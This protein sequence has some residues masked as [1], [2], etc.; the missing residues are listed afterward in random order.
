[1]ATAADHSSRRIR[2]GATTGVGMIT[3]AVEAEAGAEAGVNMVVPIFD[4][5]HNVFVA[6][7]IWLYGF[8]SP[9]RIHSFIRIKHLANVYMLEHPFIHRQSFPAGF[10]LLAGAIHLMDSSPFL[11]WVRLLIFAHSIRLFN[12]NLLATLI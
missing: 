12:Q 11:I 8:I 10:T 2:G 6:C 5:Y 3:G 1:V 4:G 9:H 7:Y